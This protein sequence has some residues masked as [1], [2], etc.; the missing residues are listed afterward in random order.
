MAYCS[1]CGVELRDG[2]KFCSGCG[3]AVNDTSPKQSRRET[4]YEG[5]IHKC[6]NCGEVLNS[7]VANCPSCGYEL[8]DIET[9]KEIRI[10]N[11]RLSRLYD[12][13]QKVD[14]IREYP[15]PNSKEAI[16]EFVNLASA[17]ISSYDRDGDGTID[18][19]EQAIIDAWKTLQNRCRDKAKKIYAMDSCEM[20]EIEELI[21]KSEKTLNQGIRKTKAKKVADTSTSILSNFLKLLWKIIKF[22]GGLILKIIKELW[23]S[24]FGKI[25]LIVLVLLGLLAIANGFD[26]IG[27]VIEGESIEW[28]DIKLSE[29]APQPPLAS[30]KIMTNSRERFYIY[31]IK[32]SEREFYD[33][34]D[35]CKEFGYD[36]EILDENEHKYVAF[37]SEGYKIELTYI[38]NLSVELNV[39]MKMDSIEWPSSDIGKLVPQP[40]STYGKI[41]WQNEN[42]FVIYVGNV[43]LDAYRVYAGLVCNSGFD[44]DVSEG[45]TYFRA[46]NAECYHISIEYIGFSTIMIRV[47][48]PDTIKVGV[49]SEELKGKDYQDVIEQ[50]K[51][52]G[53]IYIEAQEDGWNLFQTSETVKSVTIDGKTSFVASDEFK[54][55]VKIVIYYYK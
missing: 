12:R 18:K 23:K 22:I 30:G 2:D 33:Y 54:E 27:S 46:D 36:Y 35:A 6:P 29:H 10:F 19:S 20:R 41:D 52:Q 43:T 34:V 14:F 42:G 1:N 15:I 4:V 51:K 3:T 38:L 44:V 37:N 55:N 7:F 47:D 26:S 17:N 9:S 25:V 28:S 13:N 40:Q 24:T 11:A 31:D 45:D 49:S 5:E 53:F 32:C 21:G 50:L 48:E 39:P 8:R 16:W